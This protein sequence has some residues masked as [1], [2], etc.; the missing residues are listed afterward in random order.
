MPCFCWMGDNEIEEEMK[1]IRDHMKEIV[2]QA[3][4]IHGKGDL[5]PN[6]R[7]PGCTPRSILKDCHDL[8]DDL[9]NEKCKEGH[10]I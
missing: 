7:N 3:K 8:L 1:I 5:Y 10:A 4:I 6:E 2:K 9:Y